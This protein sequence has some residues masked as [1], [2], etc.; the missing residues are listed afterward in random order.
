MSKRVV[1]IGSGINSLC[2]GVILAR[3]GH[4]VILYEKNEWLGGN[5]RTKELDVPGF[6]HEIFSGFHPL[7]TTGPF[8]EELKD[9]LEEKGLHYLNTENPTGVLLPDGRAAVLHDTRE[10]TIAALNGIA[11]GEGDAYLAAMNKFDESAQ[12]V[13]GLLGKEL[14]S[15]AGAGLAA[16]GVWDL[17]VEG[18]LEFLGEALPNARKWLDNTFENDLTKALMAPWVLHTGLGPDD[19][20]SSL[21]LRVILASFEQTGMPVP[22][23]GG[24]ELVRVLVEIIE[25]NGGACHTSSTVEAITT[26]NGKVSGVTVAGQQIEADLVVANV[27]PT[28]LYEQL[29]PR[30]EVPEA[31]R[32]DTANYRYGRGNMQIHLAL[33]SPPAWPDERLL[34]TAMVH[35]T[36]GLN[37]VSR[38]VNA[39]VNGLLPAQATIVVGQHTALD[40]GRAPAGKWTIWMQLQELPA[41]P[42]GDEAGEIDCAGEWTD[43]IA[44][45]YADR[46]VNRIAKQLPGFKE[47]IL[48][49]HVISP[50]ELARINPNLVGGD[51]YSGAASLDQ[52]LFWRPLPALRG[53]ET[54]VKN[55]YHIGASTHPGPG[56]NGTSG[57]LVA[58]EV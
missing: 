47:S 1:I 12:L 53:H 55:L 31:V 52:F 49:R 26:D 39:A 28:A 6:K 29:L 14:W 58:K 54:P 13:F 5:I 10:K 17:G 44:Q 21:M 56:L 45:A 41:Y 16:K 2:A 48:E 8:Y 43:A 51:P 32:Q 27:T 57:Y 30:A 34:S 3:K 4:E 40:P 25:E 50:A 19:Q 20:A 33:D 35:V 46:I 23:G 15:L 37:G 22:K 11:A 7:F 38:A 24:S 9:I 36:P 42:T 18:M